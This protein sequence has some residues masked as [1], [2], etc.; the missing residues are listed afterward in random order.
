LV[1]LS[2]LRTAVRHDL[3]TPPR[4]IKVRRLTCVAYPELEGVDSVELERVPLR[5]AS[6]LVDYCAQVVPGLGD[7]HDGDSRGCIDVV[8]LLATISPPPAA[9]RRSGCAD[10]PTWMS[11]F[12]Q[13]ATQPSE[14]LL[15]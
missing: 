13:T 1:P 15:E 8:V 2:G 14:I 11:D 3:E 7:G 12:R 4:S 5:L 6:R 9:R 10:A